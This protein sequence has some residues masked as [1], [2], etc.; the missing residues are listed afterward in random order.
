MQGQGRL[1]PL[2]L[3]DYTYERNAAVVHCRVLLM[4][5][6]CSRGIENGDIR[7]EHKRFHPMTNIHTDPAN[8][9]TTPS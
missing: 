8:P 2:I 1:L 7:M 9:P 4:I 3:H 6:V 5:L